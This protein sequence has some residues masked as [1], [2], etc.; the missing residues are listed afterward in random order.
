MDAR[1]E[2]PSRGIRREMH[3]PPGGTPWMLSSGFGRVQALLA[4][5]VWPL[6][7]AKSLKAANVKWPVQYERGD[8][9]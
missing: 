9:F 7:A 5:P 3:L 2:L 6:R 8:I 4:D 1:L